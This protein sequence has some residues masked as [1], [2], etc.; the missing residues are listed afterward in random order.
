MKRFGKYRR[1]LWKDMK[2]M[3]NME[4]KYFLTKQLTF[5]ISTYLSSIFSISFH[6]STWLSSIF[7]TSFHF[8]TYFSSIFVISFHY[9]T[10]FS[11]QNKLDNGIEID[12][13]RQVLYMEEQSVE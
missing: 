10:Y 9:S 2:N 13:N 8:S 12:R 7:F 6:Y 11:T 3:E 5:H 4:E 1:K